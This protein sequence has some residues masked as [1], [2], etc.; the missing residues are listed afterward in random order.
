MDPRVEFVSEDHSSQILNLLQFQNL[1]KALTLKSQPNISISTKSKVKILTKPSF[2]ILTKIQHPK[3]QE[4]VS[5]TI[6]IT[7]I[8]NSNN[9]NKY[10]VGIFTC[11]IYYVVVIWVSQLVSD[12]H[13]QWSD[14]GP[15][16]SVIWSYQQLG[17]LTSSASLFLRF[18]PSFFSVWERVRAGHLGHVQMI[19]VESQLIRQW[20]RQSIQW[21]QYIKHADYQR[22]HWQT[23]EQ[24]RQLM[25]PPNI[26]NS[27]P[28]TTSRDSPLPSL[29][30]LKISGG[31]FHDCAVHDI[32]LITW[33]LGEYPTEV[34]KQFQLGEF[35]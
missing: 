8:S 30:Y 9:L 16:K 28:Q 29:D 33:I 18:D 5:N 24:I 11:Y 34:C 32:D 15:I 2:K 13:S 35:A 19:K 22:T 6:L 7:D 21:V 3:L 25:A 31:I 4:T 17:A 1:D 14:S 12:K 26:M 27:Y 10:W 20:N 23:N